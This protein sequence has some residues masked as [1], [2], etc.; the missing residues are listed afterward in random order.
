MKI[1]AAILI[2]VVPG[3]VCGEDHNDLILKTIQAMPSGGVYAKYRKELPEAN[4]FD[5]LYQTVADLDKAIQP[6]LGGKLRVDPDKAK[7][8]SFCSSAT[9]LLF[10]EV[11]EQLQSKGKAP[12]NAK[13]SRELA[14]VGD[15]TEVIHGKLDGVGIFGHWNADGPGTAVLFE[16]LNLGP[17]FSDYANAKPGDFMKIWWNENIG[18]GERGHLVVYLGETNGGDAVRVWS[19]QTQNDDG[20]AGYGEMA[21][22]KSRIKRVVFS[23]LE[24]PANLEKWLALTDSEKTSD[25]LVRI[26]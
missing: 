1:V 21:V 23:R 9:Y 24:N 4:R 26:R 12:K 19:S 16:R 22:E 17:N 7:S 20:S 15:K 18:K 11:I 14:A 13:L 6:G 25:Y 8:H 3:F 5:D 10:A 2:A